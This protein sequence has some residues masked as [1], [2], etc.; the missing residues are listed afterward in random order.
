MSIASPDRMAT[1]CP[2]LA[3]TEGLPRRIAALSMMSSCSNVKLWKTSTAAAAGMA[4]WGWSEKIPQ[5]SISNMGR[6]RFPVIVR[7]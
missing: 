2:H 5:V 7:E 4:A 6:N 3:K 1:F